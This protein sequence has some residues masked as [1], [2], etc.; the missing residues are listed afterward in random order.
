MNIAKK[1]TLPDAWKLYHDDNLT[2]T[3]VAKKLGCSITTAFILLSGH[4]DYKD[5]SSNRAKILK[6]E[7]MEK[8]NA[9]RNP[10]NYHDLAVAQ[11]TDPEYR[12]ATL[13]GRTNNLGYQ[14]I[15]LC[16]DKQKTAILA[17]FVDDQLSVAAIAKL[18]TLSRSG[19][20]AFLQQK[21]TPAE[22]KSMSLRNHNVARM[23]RKNPIATKHMISSKI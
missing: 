7:R 12:K 11:W 10:E 16:S 1:A 23:R 9:N 3:I 8:I 13:I 22:Y 2:I 18:Y 21:L 5:F 20:T 4:P 17:S 19:I 14:Y 6:K 15:E